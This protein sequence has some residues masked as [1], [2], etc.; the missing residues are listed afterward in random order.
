M[1]PQNIRG[2]LEA[3]LEFPTDLETVLNEIGEAEID[4]PNSDASMTITAILGHMNEGSYETPDELREI[5]LAN[6]P[7]EYVGRSRYSDRGP[8]GNRP[9]NGEARDEEQES[10]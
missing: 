6:V 3:E 8:A 4:A 9:A 7:E 10:F 2:Y 1:E 5:I